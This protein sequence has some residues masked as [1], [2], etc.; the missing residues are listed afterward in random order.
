MSKVQD[1]VLIKSK[2]MVSNKL[3]NG[4]TLNLSF[5]DI[6]NKEFILIVRTFS[7]LSIANPQRD[8][9]EKEAVVVVGFALI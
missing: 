1:G 4:N 6:L 5:N 9:L 8:C 7:L 3:S 2:E